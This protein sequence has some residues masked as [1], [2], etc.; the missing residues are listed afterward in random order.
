MIDNNVKLIALTHAPANSGLMNPAAGVGA[1]AKAHDIPFILDVA[2]TAGQAPL[3]V[4][5][6]GCQMLVA[7]GRKF[8]R[9]PRG[10]AFAYIAPSILERLEVPTI[11]NTTATLSRDAEILISGGA[12]RFEIW[13]TNIA[14]RHAL[15]RAIDYAMGWGLDNIRARVDY[16][17]GQLRTR[18]GGVKGVE[19]TDQGIER[20]GI[21]CMKVRNKDPYAVLG[22]LRANNI[23]TA[24]IHPVQTF[25]DSQKRSL[26]PLLRASVHYYNTESELDVFCDVL[27]RMIL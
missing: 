3:D 21:V 13:E 16:L 4:K 9:G 8:L 6:L 24:V 5:A 20:C 17:A 18:L 12:A 11:S 26:P 27:E 19:L 14:A 1:I 15:G 10:T 2:Q 25:L 22:Q 23:N 7:T